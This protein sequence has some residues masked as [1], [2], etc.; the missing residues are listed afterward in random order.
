MELQQLIA[1]AFADRALLQQ[2]EYSNAVKQ[3]IEEVDKGRLR[4][5]TPTTDGWQVNEWVKQAIFWYS[6]NGNDGIAAI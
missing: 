2:T 4:T 5:A 3:V 1:A 6:T